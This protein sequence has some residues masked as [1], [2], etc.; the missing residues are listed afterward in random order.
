MPV[1]SVS[2]GTSATLILAAQSRRK[3]TLIFNNSAATVFI[4]PDS[5]ITTSNA[6]PVLTQTS[7]VEDDG[8]QRMYSGDIYG[9]VASGSSDVRVWERDGT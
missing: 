4:G 6:F 5:T 7:F 3:S 9:I 2:V 1:K 8:N